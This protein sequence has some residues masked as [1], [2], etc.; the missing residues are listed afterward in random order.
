MTVSPKMSWSMANVLKNIELRGSTVGS[1]KEFAD[2]VRFVQEHKL[3]PVVSKV[4]NGLENLEGLDDLFD[5]MKKGSQ[6]GK[7]VVSI[8]SEDSSSK[9]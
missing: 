7:L 9:L 8:A 3:V 4:A 1:R 5:E 2:M 6:F